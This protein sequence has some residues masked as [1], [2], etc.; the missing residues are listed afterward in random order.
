MPYADAGTQPN[1]SRLLRF[2]FSIGPTSGCSLSVSNAPFI[3]AATIATDK[4][5]S[6]RC[7]VSK[8]SNDSTN[9]CSGNE[10][11]LADAVVAVEV[12]TM[13]AQKIPNPLCDGHHV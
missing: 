1:P 2:S 11:L 8:R 12:S 13:V 6:V 7:D 9:A 10:G 3:E 5:S 4:A